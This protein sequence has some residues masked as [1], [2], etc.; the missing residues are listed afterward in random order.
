M[1]EDLFIET[2][3]SVVS[4]FGCVVYGYLLVATQ[5]STMFLSSLDLGLA[6]FDSTY[7]IWPVV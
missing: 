4:F 1:L 7:V 3:R 2:Q 5:R 6:R